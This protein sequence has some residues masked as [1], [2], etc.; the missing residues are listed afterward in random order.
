MCRQ[1]ERQWFG[2]KYCSTDIESGLG[3]PDF[4]K[5]AI[6]FGFEDVFSDGHG[7]NT[8]HMLAHLFAYTGPAFLELNIHPDA[9]LMSQARFGKPIEDM[10]PEL[11]REELQQ[12][13]LIPIL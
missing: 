5:T 11:S 4:S 6:A 3:F 8:E 13:M 9:Q 10:E 2:G 12:Q 1:T 7:S